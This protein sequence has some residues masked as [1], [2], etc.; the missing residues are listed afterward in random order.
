M[1]NYIIRRLLLLIP[2]LLGITAV[3]F[4]VMALAPGD[5]AAVAAQQA[6]GEGVDAETQRAIEQYYRE[7]YGLDD[8][9]IV[10]Y[11]RWLHRVSPIGLQTERWPSDLRGFGITWETE[12]DEQTHH[13][14]LGFKPMDLGRSFAR[15]RPVTDVIATA[16]PITI[17]LSLLSTPGV[18]VISVLSGIWAGRHRGGLF[19]RATG[20]F[21][22][23]LWS[24]PTIWAGVLMVGFLASDEY[25]Q[26]FPATG[27]SDVRADRMAFLPTGAGLGAS[28][29]FALYV[30]LWVTLLLSLAVTA[31][32]GGWVAARGLA[33]AKR[34]GGNGGLGTG[35]GVLVVAALIA[36]VSAGVLYSAILPERMPGL[37]RGWLVD[38][39]WHL[40]LPVICLSYAGFAFLSKLARGAVLENLH[41]DY[42]RTARAKGLD[43]RTVLF[44]HVVRNSLLPLITV[45][46]TIFPALLSGSVVVEKIFS[47]NGMGLL[48]VDSVFERDR[49]VVMAITLIA[50]LIG[51][52]TIIVQDVLYA[53]AD[54][55]VSFE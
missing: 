28:L 51:L 6:A 8:P 24:V 46:V 19:D 20:T 35:A 34:A 25:F 15:G 11:G 39:I 48:A 10:Q 42:A 30:S 38:R 17:L 55:R 43:D 9:R 5:P 7:R 52:L 40:V 54:P 21:Y 12:I 3:V 18:Y 45:F 37:E 33:G 27:L 31:M 16:L 1:V 49:E 47:I 26:W 22:L 32:A 14:S 13:R 44:R 4:F 53:V 50:G 29:G 23:A 36:G 41:A 2:T